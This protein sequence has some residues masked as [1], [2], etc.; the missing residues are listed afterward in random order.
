MT[1]RTNNPEMT[2]YRAYDIND[3]FLSL[4]SNVIRKY[5]NKYFSLLLEGELHNVQII[6][7]RC[8]VLHFVYIL[9]WLGRQSTV[10]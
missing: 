5:K 8:L 7:I 2:E 9:F 3:I 1:A 10:E 4:S 6:F